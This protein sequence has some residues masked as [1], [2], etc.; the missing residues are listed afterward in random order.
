MTEPLSEP[1]ATSSAVEV[2]EPSNRGGAGV[3]RGAFL[4]CAL[5]AWMVVIFLFSAQP[6]SA[7]V[8]RNYFHDAN[9]VVRKFAH[10]SEYAILVILA[11]TSFSSH[12]PAAQSASSPDRRIAFNAGIAISVL[13]AISDEIHQ[14]FVPGR[15]AAIS[16]VF[17]DS[18]GVIFGSFLISYFRRRQ[19]QSVS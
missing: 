5:V 4:Y 18:A 2:S 13:Y 11:I 19:R 14:A 16:D 10:F 15:G 6:H 17:V 7:E 8:T 12:I 9:F 1:N 3:M